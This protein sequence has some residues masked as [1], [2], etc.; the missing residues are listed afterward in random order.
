MIERIGMGRRRWLATASVIGL[1]AAAGTAAAEVPNDNF[2]PNAPPVLA[3]PDAINGIGNI[4]V[5]TGGGSVGV[6]TGSLINPRTVL[7]AAH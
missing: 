2:S 3:D 1:I 7:F 5:D 4:I 6:C